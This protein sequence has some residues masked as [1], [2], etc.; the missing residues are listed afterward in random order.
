MR[1]VLVATLIAV[2]TLP[3]YAQT[4]NGIGAAQGAS[5][6]G[7]AGAP[8]QESAAAVA[9]KKEEQKANERAF[10]DAV[11]RIPTPDKKYDPWGNVRDS[12]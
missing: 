12:K 5:R 8:Q 3:A 6:A 7:A 1:I 4:M 9:K 2:T 10:N 11:K